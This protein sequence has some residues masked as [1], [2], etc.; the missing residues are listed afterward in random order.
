MP[1]RARRA[2]AGRAAPWLPHHISPGRINVTFGNPVHCWREGAKPLDGLR[3]LAGSAFG[4]DRLATDHRGGDVGRRGGGRAR[5]CRLV[6][7]HGVAPAAVARASR[8]P[9]KSHAEAGAAGSWTAC[10]GRIR[11]GSL[12]PE[13][14]HRCRVASG[15]GSGT[16]TEARATSQHQP[17][18][19]A[20]DS[21]LLD[22]S[23]CTILARCSGTSSWSNAA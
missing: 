14:K 1:G 20:F 23:C 5:P 12:C 3:H 9:H 2:S 17:I 8:R 16:K 18:T 22:P 21:R 15:R 13:G 19:I 4:G 6:G 11:V 10:S 7:T